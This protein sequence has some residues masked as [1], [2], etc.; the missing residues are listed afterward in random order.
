[1]YDPPA[2]AYHDL[3]KTKEQNNKE[4]LKFQIPAPGGKW[5]MKRN[6]ERGTKPSFVDNKHLNNWAI[7]DLAN[8]QTGYIKQFVDKLY[9]EGESIGY[10]VE[11]PLD[12]QFRANPRNL[13]YVLEEFRKLCNIL[14]E[15]ASKAGPAMIVVI[16]QGRNALLYNGLK[17]EG[18]VVQRISTQVIQQKNV[19]V[20]KPATLHNILLKINS[21]LGGTN[22]TLHR[23]NTPHI[24]SSPVMIM[25]ADVTHASR[26]QKGTKP[27]IAAVV[28]SMD[29]RASQYECQVRFQV[30]LH[31]KVFFD[32]LTIFLSLNN[33]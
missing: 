12:G 16:S 27:S 8:T 30:T 20:L 18:D 28:A 33:L 13:A 23:S 6:A 26:D 19:M 14:T 22:Q 15:R 1:M 2:L 31:K 32:V 5:D 9:Q 24:L 10:N 4:A 11:F 25:G 7:L 17:H 29:P 3:N 21:K